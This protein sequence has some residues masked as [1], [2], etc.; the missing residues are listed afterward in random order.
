MSL[1]A[2]SLEDGACMS[3]TTHGEVDIDAIWLDVEVVDALVEHH[4][5]MVCLGGHFLSTF[6]TSKKYRR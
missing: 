1:G 6:T 2:K 5:D 4:G 3:A